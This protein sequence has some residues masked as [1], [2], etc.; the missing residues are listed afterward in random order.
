MLAPALPRAVCFFALGA[1]FFAVS[2]FFRR[3]RPSL[4]CLAVVVLI[5]AG[6]APHALRFDASAWTYAM[7]YN[8]WG[9]VLFAIAFVIAAV[10]PAQRTARSDWIDGLVLGACASLLVFLKISYGLLG[11]TLPLIALRVHGWRRGLWLAAITGGAAT[12]I[13]F[14]IALDWSFGSMVRDIALASQARSALGLVALGRAALAIYPDAVALV[15]LAFVLAGT[16]QP[17]GF[18]LKRILTSP[19][20]LI[21]LS[22][23]GYTLLISMG[24]SPLGRFRENPLLLVAA[25]CCVGSLPAQSDPASD[26]GLLYPRSAAFLLPVIGFLLVLPIAVRFALPYL[27]AA[28]RP[29][30]EGLIERGMFTTSDVVLL[31]ALGLA[32]VSGVLLLKR[33]LLP[34][35][36]AAR[37][38]CGLAIFVMVAPILLRNVSSMAQVVRFK[39]EDRALSPAEQLTSGPLKGLQIKGA[40][41]VAAL[42]GTYAEKIRDGVRLLEQTGNRDKPAVAIDFANPLNVARGVRPSRRS[43]TCWHLNFVYS[44]HAAPA[45]EAVFEFDDRIMIPKVF[46]DPNPENQQAIEAHYGA[47]LRRHFIAAGESEQWILLVPKTSAP[48]DASN[49]GAGE[50]TR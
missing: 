22:A 2:P 36:R 41:G 45:A 47:F 32:Y 13:F 23:I 1:L 29:I 5:A 30:T 40:G 17:N 50:V 20:M 44:L 25:L 46:G 6:L 33:G 49:A 34:E 43:P 37:A 24:N 16:S 39:L 35:A 11:L 26:R 31:G 12:I 19:W 9:F 3:L 28:F 10:A 8:R 14:G 21:A 42:P 27:S 48:S 7:I 38:F 4:A 15:L 18:G